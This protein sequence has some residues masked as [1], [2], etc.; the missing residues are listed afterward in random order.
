MLSLLDSST[1]FKM[2]NIFT[3]KIILLV[4]VVLLFCV[5]NL[6]DVC[7]EMMPILPHTHFHHVGT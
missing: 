7:V 4:I 2:T 6:V 1:I 3:F 5:S